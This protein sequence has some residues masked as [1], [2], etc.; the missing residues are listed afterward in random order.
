MAC[1][2]TY[3]NQNCV[4][5]GGHCRCNTNCAGGF[6]A[7]GD[8]GPSIASMIG[9]LLGT[10]LTISSVS[11]GTLAA[12]DYIYGTSDNSSS[13]TQTALLSGTRIVSILSGSGGIG[14]YQIT[15]QTPLTG[16]QRGTTPRISYLQ[17]TKQ[18]QGILSFTDPI[19]STINNVRF[20]HIDQLRNAVDSERA[21]RLAKYG[22][23]PWTFSYAW[24][25]PSL[26]DG[27]RGNISGVYWTELR[28]ALNNITGYTAIPDTYTVADIVSATKMTVLRAKYQ[29]MRNDCVCN[30]NCNSYST[31]SCYSDC[32]CH[33]NCG[34]NYSDKNLKED[35]VYI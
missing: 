22:T 6:S 31:C 20:V 7:P 5:N 18:T 4:C 23:T 34:C 32:G 2:G 12:G 10:T 1:D 8:Y 16:P 30:S 29:E 13:S 9:S 28:D 15:N 25:L 11:Q 26:P 24:P 33:N 19:L 3:C 35:I 21:R 17:V 14:T 27:S